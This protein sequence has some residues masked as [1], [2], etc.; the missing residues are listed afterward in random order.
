MEMDTLFCNDSGIF[1]N[2]LPSE[3]GFGYATKSDTVED[4]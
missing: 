3:T 2:K 1:K 4:F